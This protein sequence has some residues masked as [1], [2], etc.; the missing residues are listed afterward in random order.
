MYSH[1]E[2]SLIIQSMLLLLQIII[3]EFSLNLINEFPP[4]FPDHVRRRFPDCFSHNKY[5]LT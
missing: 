5:V 2:L 3:T 1:Q 4:T